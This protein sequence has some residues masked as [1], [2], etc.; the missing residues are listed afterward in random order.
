MLSLLIH[1]AGVVNYAY[2]IYFQL[3]LLHIP[4][5][6]IK[7]RSSFAGPWKF[8]T[9]WNLWLQLAF[10][11][12]GL[13]NSLFGMAS[14]ALIT[15]LLAAHSGSSSLQSSSRSGLQRLRDWLFATQAFPIGVF[16]GGVF[17]TL[18]NIDRNLIF[19]AKL[20]AF[21]PPFENHVLHTS[22]LVLQLLELT[23]TYHFF[24][25]N[26]SSGLSVTAGF[27]LAYLAWVCAIAYL[28]GGYWVYPVMRVR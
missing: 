7:G 6:A 25:P 2:G 11:L 1:T 23:S 9:F 18:Y 15:P 27:C 13:L 26:R 8:L 21:I 4:E 12:V 16:V 24:P 22:V 19:P 14:M 17:W 28:T 20:D 10:H 3:V 5:G